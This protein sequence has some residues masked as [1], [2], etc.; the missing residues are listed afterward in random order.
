MALKLYLVRHGETDYNKNKD[1]LKGGQEGEISLN[2]LGILQSKRLS[3]RLKNI[4]F[5]K[6]FS[7]PLKRAIQTA[8]KLSESFD[9]EVIVD[10]RLKEYEPGKVDPS[11]EKWKTKYNEIL[12]SGMSKYDIRPFGGDNIWDLIKRAGSFLESMQKEE[13]TILA[14]AHSG[15]NEA[16]IS[17]SQKRALVKP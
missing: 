17:L 15:V 12:A 13:G 4:S 6:I 14:I 10:D 5:D 2:E 16:F 1:T 9:K 8:N 3:N 11:S 7:S